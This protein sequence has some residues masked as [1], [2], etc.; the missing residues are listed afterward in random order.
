MRANIILIEECNCVIK[1]EQVKVNADGK[2]QVKGT[3]QDISW[4]WKFKDK[5]LKDG[6]VFEQC[7]SCQNLEKMLTQYCKL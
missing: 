6:S 7:D 1:D 2:L 3:H 5:V 4:H